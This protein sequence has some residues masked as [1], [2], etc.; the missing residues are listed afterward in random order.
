MDGASSAF[1]AVA[2]AIQLFGTVQETRNFVKD[3]NNAPR[4]LI[5]LGEDLDQLT[6]VLGLVKQLLEHQFLVLGLPG[7]PIF[8]LDPL[9]N[10]ERI[11]KPL[12]EI[13]DKAKEAPNDRRAKRIWNLI[14]FGMKKGRVQELQSQLRDAKSDLQFA[15]LANSWQLQ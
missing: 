2:L 11:H 15:V 8:L 13:V 9:Q 6:S 14:R 4:E 5:K 10:C 12:K 1:A 7:S 3:L